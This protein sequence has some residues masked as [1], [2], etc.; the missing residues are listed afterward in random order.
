MD[1]SFLSKTSSQVTPIL[2]KLYDSHKLYGLAK[3][4]KPEARGE[5]TSAVVELFDMQLSNNEQELIADVLME[6]LRQAEIDLREALAH[7]LAARDD[8]PLRLALEMANDEIPVAKPI[9]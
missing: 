4:K 2:V 6:L 9:L 7:K 8:I 1:L 5:L 3:D